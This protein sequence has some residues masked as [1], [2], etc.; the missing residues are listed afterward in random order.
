MPYGGTKLGWSMPR[1]VS[2]ASHTASFLS[3]LARPG[4]FFT[5]RALTSCTVRPAASSTACQTR[6][7]SPVDSTVTTSMPSQRRWSASSVTAFIVA[8]TVHTWCVRRPG[9]SLVCGTRV[10]TTPDAFATSTAATRW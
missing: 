1:S 4:T 3:V 8:P 6:Q 7:Y 2:F 9:R 10:H 5:D